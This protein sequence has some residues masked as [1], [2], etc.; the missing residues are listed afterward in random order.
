[1]YGKKFCEPNPYNPAGNLRPSDGVPPLCV[2]LTD[3]DLPGP[4]LRLH[5]GVFRVPAFTDLKLHDITS[6][7]GDPNREPLDQNQPAGSVGF[8]A[9]NSRFITRKLW[10][11]ANQH[12]FMHHGQFTTM[13]QAVLAHAGEAAAS[14]S[15]FKGLSPYDQDSVIEFLKSLQILLKESESMCVNEEGEP[16]SCPAGVDP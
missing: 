4:R 11:I 6:G 8:F 10:G 7:P 9:G 2:D 12:P 3:D 14:S 1:L 5:G 15:G 13:R 16:I